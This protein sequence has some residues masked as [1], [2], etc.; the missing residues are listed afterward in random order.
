M[1][2]SSVELNLFSAW[3]PDEIM[4]LVDRPDGAAGGP[5]LFALE[6]GFPSTGHHLTHADPFM[7]FG[8]AVA[9]AQR[10]LQAGQRHALGFWLC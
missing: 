10:I 7:G 6:I 1:F 5:G 4:R 3:T 8:G 2:G 9:L